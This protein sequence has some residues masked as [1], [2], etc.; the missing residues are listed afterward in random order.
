MI[1][2]GGTLGDG[3][4]PAMGGAGGSPAGGVSG[5]GATAG[6]GGGG[7]LGGGT[8]DRI[9]AAYQAAVTRAKRC[10][11]PGG[12]TS[13]QALVSA[14]LVCNCKTFVDDATGLDLIA[15]QWQASGCV[16]VCQA[17]CT[18]PPTSSQ[19]VTAGDNAPGS[20]TDVH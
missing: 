2:S 18:S 7:G 19:C 15:A 11:I 17:A 4:S 9:G 1:A 12:P 3:G 6:A 14:S 8:C 13:C 20:C 10:P 16:Q 5:S